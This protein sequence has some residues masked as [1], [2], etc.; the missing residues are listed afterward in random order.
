MCINVNHE[1]VKMCINVDQQCLEHPGNEK[2]FKDSILF[3]EQSY[4]VGALNQIGKLD[5]ESCQRWIRYY[6]INYFV[7]LLI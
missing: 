7:I 4:R 5:Q 6:F 1:C 3:S 2:N